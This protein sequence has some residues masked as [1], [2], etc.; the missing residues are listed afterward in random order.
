MGLLDDLAKDAGEWWEENKGNVFP[1][2]DPDWE[3]WYARAQAPADDPHGIADFMG[4]V[5]TGWDGR[6]HKWEIGT[7]H[8]GGY[9]EDELFEDPFASRQSHIEQLRHNLGGGELQTGF[10]RDGRPY[11]TYFALGV[12][13]VPTDRSY[14]EE[15][16]GG[17]TTDYTNNPERARE[18]FWHIDNLNDDVMFTSP[19]GAFV[20]PTVAPGNDINAGDPFEPG[21]AA[22]VHPTMR[23][24]STLIHE[25]A[26]IPTQIIRDV[27]LE[28]V[29]DLNTKPD[30]RYE[31]INMMINHRKAMFDHV[32][33]VEGG[34]PADAPT[35][36]EGVAHAMQGS[37][38][39]PEL[40]G[41]YA[42]D[43]AGFNEASP[44]LGKWLREKINESDMKEFMILGQA[45]A[46]LLDERMYG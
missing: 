16:L 23:T 34:L 20:S 9:M 33:K 19:F 14:A 38:F 29:K 8:G 2:L 18:I 17:F 46:G 43:P 25:A 13:D 31:A 37:E 35:I 21:W 6:A 12:D 27:G 42:A 5:H 3:P 4:Q 45:P 11:S 26:H 44:E 15:V 28:A 7:T 22:Y 40:I 1:H 36:H 41:I 24:P 39:I 10:D 32:A 30:L